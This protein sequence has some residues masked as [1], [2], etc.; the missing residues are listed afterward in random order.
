MESQEM[1]TL[2]VKI[3]S[4]FRPGA[5][6]DRFTLFA[7]RG[8]QI[9][10]II[11]A[12]VQPGRHVVMFG[13][14]GVGKTSLA[15][16]LAEIL[17]DAGVQLLNSG[18][19]NCDGTDNFGSLWLKIFRELTIIM[20]RSGIGFIS[21]IEEQHSLDSMLPEVITP[22]DIRYVLSK[23]QGSVIII[24]D[25][26]DRIKD[27]ETT[28]LLADTIKNLSDHALDVTLILVGVADAV[29]ELITEHRS[30][31]RALVQV[32]MPRMS[33]TELTQIIDRGLAYSGMTI[34]EHAADRIT[35]LSQG[36]PHYTHLLGLHA[37]LNAIDNDRT[38]IDM[39]DVNAATKTA[40]EKAH[41]ILSAYHK[42]TSSPQKQNLYDE[43][44]LAC[45]LAATDELGYFSAAAVAKPLSAI[46]NKPYYIPSFS[47]HLTDFCS[48]KRGPI[49]QKIGE[50]R[51]FRF[52]FINPLLQPFIIMH[53]LATGLLTDEL[54]WIATR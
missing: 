41:S 40:V 7:G 48:D 24:L 39:T 5:P 51:R 36:L 54:L 30:I 52:R 49:L 44:L 10:E 29:D 16:V 9:N 31:E 2:R 15:K 17:S 27:K 32:P 25:E 43:V 33:P 35:R 19:I 18:T 11:Q 42:A 3:A 13:E 1:N 12:T 38:H 47:R 28:T 53:G 50:S 21:E 34:D 37:A 23:I 4:V 20:R 26:I 45:A 8:P 6:V 22:D 46:M 14:R